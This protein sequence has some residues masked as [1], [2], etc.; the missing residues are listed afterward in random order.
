[1]EYIREEKNETQ[2]MSSYWKQVEYRSG[3]IYDLLKESGQKYRNNIAY[4]FMGK[5]VTY[6][7]FLKQVDRASAAL[8]VLGVKEDE[9]VCIAMPNVPQALIFFYA[10][11]RIGAVVN[12][13][14]PLS[15]PQEIKSFVNRVKAHT[16]LVMDQFY[17]V[18]KQ[19]RAETELQNVIVASAGEAVPFI[20]KLPY[21]LTQ[22]RKIKKPG[23]NDNAIL[24][25]D[26]MRMG[27]N[28]SPVLPTKDRTNLPAVI[29]HS[30]GT[31]GKIKG[32]CHSNFAV[33]AAVL[34]M[35]AT[36]NYLPKEKMLTIM[37]IFHGNG[38]VI[39]VHLVLYFG[40]C[41][42]LIPR[43]SPQ[44]YVSDLLKNRCNHTSGVPT[45]FEKII[46]VPEMKKADLSFL[47]GVYCGADALT[48]ELQNKINRFLREH[49]SPVM[50]RQGYG[51]TEGIVATTL[52]PVSE[53]REGSIGLPLPDVTLKIVAPGTD[54][55]LPCGEVGEI[56]FSSVTNML[57]YYDDEEETNLTLKLHS[58]GRKYIHSG[59]LGYV[60]KDGF[61]FFKGRLKRMI[62]TNGYNVYPL[63]LENIIQKHTFVQKCCVVGLPDKERIEKVAVF[64]VLA[65]GV[66]PDEKTRLLLNDYF[67]ENIAKYAIPRM[68]VFVDSF[69]TT[70]VGKIDY[71]KLITDHAEQI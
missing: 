53:Q 38:L 63:E 17:P 6:G 47:R 54:V 36:G 29:L 45:L 50:I 12:M 35:N 8:S 61:V 10:A 62:V 60:D 43:F 26:F 2:K 18:V 13:I 55:E 64:T 4:D 34:Q 37:P 24:F 58:D 11:N 44:S 65:P 70:K 20:K 33:N 52:N 25:P 71:N 51:M 67:K 7:S 69:P 46:E 15:S 48:A 9:I 19:I 30:G 14:H 28:A 66:I 39:G 22:G 56:V 16:I 49:N 21:K 1:M 57:Y 59:D 68:T 41:C 27:N 3:T 5:K 40:G 42:V 31:T 23:K 32:V